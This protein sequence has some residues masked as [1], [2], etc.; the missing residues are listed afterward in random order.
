VKKNFFLL[1]TVFCGYFLLDVL[2][3]YPLVFQSE[4]LVAPDSLIP[5]ASTMALDRLQAATGS[6][7][8]W[9]PWLFSGMPTVEAFSYLSG[10]YLPNVVFNFFQT[11]GIVLQLIHLAFAGLGVCLFLRQY[12]LK[13]LAAPFGGALFMLNPYMTA[14]LVHGHGSQLMTL[15]YM[16][17]M[18]WATMRLF[19]RGKLFDAGILALIAGFQLQ[20]SH[21]QIAYYSWMLMLLLAVVLFVFD[22]GFMNMGAGHG[23]NGGQEVASGHKGRPYGTILRV[24]LLLIVALGCGVAMSASIYLP[25]S[26]YAA[27]SVRGVAAEGGGSAWEYATLWSMHPME[28]LTFLI[29]GVFGFGGVTYWGFMPFTD[30]PHY[31]GIAVLLL[32]VSGAFMRRKEPMTW[33]F[34]AGVLLALLLSFGSFF[35][36][37]F[38]LFYHFAPLFSRFRVPSMALVMLYLMISF[39]AAVG[40]NDLLQRQ[41]E[42]WL[43]PIR[44]GALFLAAILLSFLAFEQPLE[45][46]FRS[47]FPDPQVGSFDLAFMI[48]KVRWENLT[49]SLW[50]V[51][52]ITSLFAGVLWLG[53]KGRL[54]HK[55]TGM[56]LFFLAL[57]DLLWMDIQIVYPSAGSLRD[58]VF[59][60]SRTVEPAFRHD[61]ITRYLASQKGSFRIYPAGAF[62][63]ENKFALF[64]IESVG[65]YHPAKLK[66]YED[67]LQRTENIS[68]IPALKMLNV[69]YIVSPVAVEH[70]ELILVKEGTLRLASGDARVLVYQLRGSCPR[71]WFASTVIGVNGRNELFEQVLSGKEVCNTVYVDASNWRGSRSFAQGTIS[72]MSRTAERMTLKISAPAEAFFVASEVYYP[73]RWKASL[74]GRDVPVVEVNGLI[75]GVRIPPGKHELVFYYDRSDFDKGRNVSLAATG[76]AVLMLL[77]GV[78]AGRSSGK[79]TEKKKQNS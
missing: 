21:V 32:A 14:M 41:S 63:T 22:R 12:G 65:G 78:F 46:F 42:R 57:G 34:S 37:V 2:L 40:V 72:S 27:Y 36:P 68:S 7:P 75:R 39:L 9:Q 35:S 64:G 70:P 24:F 43:L 52:I 1:F 53:I 8:L 73:L 4:V 44:I 38:D 18:L 54:S 33:F 55:M 17:W 47:I 50:I 26:E 19:D 16:P 48:N 51:L 6:Y 3:F 13:T 79:M 74:D 60:E 5:Q 58:P 61:D 56:L 45:S 49:G 31:A 67:F 59:R 20:R 30:F 29:P 10:L 76:I 28:L 66:L 69:G 23:D 25:A 15:A 71:A 77:T 62:F 11:D